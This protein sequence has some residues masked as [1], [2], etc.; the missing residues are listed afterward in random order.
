MSR[1][2]P[3]TISTTVA[4]LALAA[5]VD[6]NADT[7]LTI[8]RNAASDL[9]CIPDSSVGTFRSSGVIDTNAPVGYVFTPVVRNELA[10]GSD[11]T[12]SR[13]VF[14]QGARVTIGFFDDT[15]FDDARQAQL[16]EAGLTRFSVPLSG[17]VEAGGGTA[18]IGFEIVPTELLFEIEQALPAPTEGDP[19]PSTVLDVR[20]QIYGTRGGDSISSNTFSYP[21]EVCTDC[22]QITTP[23]TC[24]QL[25][26]NFEG[27]AGG[28]CNPLQDGTLVCCNSEAGGLICPAEPRMPPKT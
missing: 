19:V 1:S 23:Q 13:S 18:T 10:A 7:G 16:E 8:L 14:L 17:S 5:C 28:V 20:V 3:I 9:D 12:S 25:D 24:E 15:L 4:A 21:V 26:P 2:L 27:S 11:M 6:N 22:L